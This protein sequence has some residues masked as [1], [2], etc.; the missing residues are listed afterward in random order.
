VV[1]NGPCGVDENL[2]HIE[3]IIYKVGIGII[4]KI[5]KCEDFVTGITSPEELCHPKKR[6]KVQ[7]WTHFLH[8]G[9]TADVLRRL[10]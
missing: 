4:G 9:K 10:F 5:D 3:T 2:T 1:E 8:A 7:I 6:D